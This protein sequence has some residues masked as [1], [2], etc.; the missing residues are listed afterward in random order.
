V[1]ALRGATPG[2]RSHHDGVESYTSPALRMT[3][4]TS[5]ANLTLDTLGHQLF[6]LKIGIPDGL[7]RMN[8]TTSLHQTGSRAN[9]APERDY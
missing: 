6:A 2:T 8:L 9:Q 5:G 1:P 3:L 7:L 4:T